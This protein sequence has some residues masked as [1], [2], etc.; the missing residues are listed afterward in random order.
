MTVT[1]LDPTARE[2]LLLLFFL[3]AGRA[4]ARVQAWRRLQRTGAVLLKNSGYAIPASPEARADCAWIKREIVGSGGQAM[5]L[6]ARAPDPPTQAEIVRAFRAARGRDFGKLRADAA[7]LLERTAGRPP[8]PASRQVTQRLRR[9]RER[10]D[11]TVALDFF[12]APERE[13]V[14]TLLRELDHRTGRTRNM[15]S[16][17]TSR[18]RA[19]DYH[20]RVWVTRPRP[21][22]DRMSSAWLIRRFIDPKARF[23]FAS[24]AA[25]STAI[26][27]DTFDAEFGHHGTHCTFE[28]FCERFAIADQAVR[29]IGRIVHDLD[30]KQAT[31]G[32]PETATVGR[33]VDGLR[34]V[35]H[36]DA[37]LLQ[38]GME[39]FEALYQSLAA[40]AAAPATSG[41]RSRRAR[42]GATRRRKQS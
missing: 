41:K 4:H 25:R 36:D 7:H 33:L 19:T 20:G 27:F 32:E 17:P 8:R 16:P 5:V 9:L 29:H 28:T 42:A 39:M 18:V 40:S 31:Y 10:F 21:G 13:Q 23:A 34:R 22:V 6:A 3:P 14:A 30:L 15:D 2:W 11:E 24:P 26:P 37:A 12:A 35:K 38:S 1:T